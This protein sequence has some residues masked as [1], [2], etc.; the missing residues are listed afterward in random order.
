MDKKNKLEKAKAELSKLQTSE[1]YYTEQ[2][3]AVGTNGRKVLMEKFLKFENDLMVE[4]KKADKF[5]DAM[6][7][8]S[9][10]FRNIDDAL[11]YKLEKIIK[12]WEERKHNSR[13]LDFDKS[14]GV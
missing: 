11:E 5:T 12:E 13:F 1:E 14:K 7:E 8:L 3:K 4:A 9:D 10:V 2:I 6:L